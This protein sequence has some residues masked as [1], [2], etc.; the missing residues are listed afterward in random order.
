MEQKFHIGVKA[1]IKDAD[2]RILVS[3]AP[4]VGYWD[5]PGGRIEEGEGIGEALSRELREELGSD[6]EMLGLFDATLAKIRINSGGDV[7]ALCL[8]VYNCR[9]R[10]GAGPDHGRAH[11]EFRWVA[12]AEAMELLGNKFQNEFL[13]K[14]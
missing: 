11:D 14:L 12:K 5:L 7:V 10:A 4:N 6:V 2:G 9:L 8:L 1:L 3:K 13:E